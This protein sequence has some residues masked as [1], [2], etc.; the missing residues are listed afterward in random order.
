MYAHRDSYYAIHRLMFQ[1]MW[2]NGESVRM[3]SN[4]RRVIEMNKS[5]KGARMERVFK[6]GGCNG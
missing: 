4:K 1:P 2:K 3:T 5:S 6:G